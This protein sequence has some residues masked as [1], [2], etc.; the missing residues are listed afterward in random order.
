[1]TDNRLNVFVEFVERVRNGEKSFL[2]EHGDLYAVHFMSCE[3]GNATFYYM[4]TGYD[5]DFY[6]ND[7]KKYSFVA[8]VVGNEIYAEELYEFGNSHYE[9]GIPDD[10][11]GG[12]VHLLSEY[13]KSLNQYMGEV[14]FPAYY[15]A[16]QTTRT[17]FVESAILKDARERLFNTVDNKKKDYSKIVTS[18]GIAFSKSEC[19]KMLT[20]SLDLPTECKKKLD[21]R[22]DTIDASKSYD[23][24][25]D[26][27]IQS[28]KA[29]QEWE[30][31]L[32]KAVNSI[33]AKFVVVEFEFN[34]KRA[35]AK[36]EPCKLIRCLIEN[37]YYSSY[38]FQ[39][40]KMGIDL[41]SAL[42]ASTNSWK[43]PDNLL[44]NKHIIRVLFRGK[45]IYERS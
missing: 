27:L 12:H 20:Y 9:N 17:G 4:A 22:K 42:G 8:I 45:P 16:L 13:L 26:N 32:A 18:F 3:V 14:A 43:D 33:D 41:L 19:M 35:S 24:A 34:G 23:I 10:F 11:C 28:G 44:Y 6:V 40:D 5:K 7:D 39:T 15:D 2:I 30:V 37:N 1:M 21:E 31:E 38:I 36:I 29:A 25:L